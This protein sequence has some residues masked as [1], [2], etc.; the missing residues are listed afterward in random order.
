MRLIIA[1]DSA[2][3]NIASKNALTAFLEAKE[4][5]VWHW[6][7]DLWLIDG[8]PNGINLPALRVEIFAA[9]PTL[10]HILIL[11]TEGTIN[12]AGSVPQNSVTW[13]DE[14]WRRNP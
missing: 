5:S 7:Q 12:H 2:V 9:I 6:Y 4:W 11:T 3:S 13:F 14:H 1:T 10:T 8:A